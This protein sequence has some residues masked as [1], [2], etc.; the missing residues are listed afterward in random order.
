MGRYISNDGF[1]GGEKK[2][3]EMMQMAILQP[4]YAILDETDSGLDV[5]SLRSKDVGDAVSPRC[6]RAKRAR[7]PAS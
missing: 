7:R 4:K 3:L 5:D 2:R 6:A 1:S